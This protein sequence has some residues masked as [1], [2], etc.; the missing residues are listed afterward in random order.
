[1]NKDIL[2]VFITS[3]LFAIRLNASSIDVCLKRPYIQTTNYG[4]IKI[5]SVSYN[6]YGGGN[7]GLTKVYSG[8]RLMYSIPR[9]FYGYI[10]I[11]RDGEHLYMINFQIGDKKKNDVKIVEFENGIKKQETKL[12]TILQGSIMD[13]PD[14]SHKNGFSFWSK[15]HNDQ[16]YFADPRQERY[17]SK[18][19]CIP[20]S[21]TRSKRKAKIR[22]LADPFLTIEDDKLNILMIDNS[23]LRIE[24]STG[25]IKRMER[26]DLRYKDKFSKKRVFRKYQRYKF[27]KRGEFPDLQNGLK[28]KEFV[29]A[30]I[31]RNT[32][33]KNI[34]GDL[35]IG[36]NLLIN[37][38]G[39]VEDIQVSMYNSQKKE[40]EVGGANILKEIVGGERFRTKAIPKGYEEFHFTSWNERKLQV[41]KE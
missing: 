24:L 15:Y 6:P 27:L 25:E 16:F 19:R 31:I 13:G 5:S 11:S 7:E 39:K 8:N 14:F 38:Q 21:K 40:L 28:F 33:F 1:M 29:K 12:S 10:A 26:F 23:Y 18:Q 35:S 41:I 36:F 2:F 22:L 30:E 20:C 37:N 17:E 9:Y 3:L 34:Y 32:K 4:E